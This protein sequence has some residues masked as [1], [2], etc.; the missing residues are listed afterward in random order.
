MYMG[1]LFLIFNINNEWR[2]YN[3]KCIN[4]TEPNIFEFLHLIELHTD[5]IIITY[6]LHCNY[7]QIT[8]LL[9]T[10][11]IACYLY[12]HYLREVKSIKNMHKF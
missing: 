6:R 10:D 8:L 11:Y 12:V 9:L 7:L 2:E 5:Y 1:K 3:S 4:E